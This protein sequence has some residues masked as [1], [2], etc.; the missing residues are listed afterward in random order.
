[1]HKLAIL[2][3]SAVLG[4]GLVGVHASASTT[5]SRPCLHYAGH[6]YEACFAYVVNDSSLALGRYYANVRGA[7][8]SKA[9]DALEDFRYRYRDSARQLIASR[10]A[11]WPRGR[12]ARTLSPYHASPSSRRAQA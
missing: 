5:T 8:S 4:A 7:D 12:V 3:V 6:V 9:G 10:V 11:A 1:M 2:V